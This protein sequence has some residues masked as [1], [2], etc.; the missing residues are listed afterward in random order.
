MLIVI[1]VNVLALVFT[2]WLVRRLLGFRRGHWVRTAVAVLAG[3][4]LTEAILM[5]KR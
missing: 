5:L 3:L 4:A 1:L 2:A